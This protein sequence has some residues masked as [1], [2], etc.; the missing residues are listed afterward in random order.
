MFLSKLETMCSDR[1]RWL[2]F[3]SSFQGN[4][5]WLFS[6]YS[7]GRGALKIT[8]GNEWKERL[9]VIAERGEKTQ[10]ERKFRPSLQSH[11][12]TTFYQL[13]LISPFLQPLLSTSLTLSEHLPHL[14]SLSC[15]RFSS[16]RLWGNCWSWLGPSWV[17]W[18]LAFRGLKSRVHRERTK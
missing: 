5:C 13:L 15:W 4:F 2:F 9:R 8:R 17:E 14:L 12:I 6:W 16:F 1:F 11:W 7:V 18:L 3:S 10:L